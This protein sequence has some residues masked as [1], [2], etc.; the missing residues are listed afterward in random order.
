MIT[1]DHFHHG[2]DR[3]LTGIDIYSGYG[4]LSLPKLLSID[5]K[6]AFPIIIVFHTALL[7]IK[8]LTSQH[9]K[10]IKEPRLMESTGFTI[11]PTILKQLALQNG[12]IAFRRLSYNTS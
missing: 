11:S 1:L 7:L 10:C 9:M 6:N 3:I 2:R 8:K 12:E 4:L 5:L